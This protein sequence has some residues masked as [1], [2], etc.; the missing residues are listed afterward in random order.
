[1]TIISDFN[2]A[3]R[4]VVQTAFKERHASESLIV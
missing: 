1:M 2:D 3:D 4:W